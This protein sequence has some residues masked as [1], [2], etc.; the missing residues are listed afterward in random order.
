[1]KAYKLV[2]MKKNGKIGSL[3]IHRQDDL[4]IGE[5]LEAEFYPTEGFAPRK[6]YHCTFKPIAPH[7]KLELKNG[8]KR[9]WVEVEVED[10]E[11][12]ERSKYYGGNWILANRM[13]IIKILYCY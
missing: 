10:Y 5:W 7:L 13:K 4:P 9:I 1:M 2:R 11:T 6:G 3:F 12:Y 8:E